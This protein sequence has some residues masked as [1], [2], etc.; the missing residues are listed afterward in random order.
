MFELQEIAVTPED[1]NYTQHIPGKTYI[2][3]FA[4][5]LWQTKKK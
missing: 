2:H 4:P 1:N 3:L 5:A